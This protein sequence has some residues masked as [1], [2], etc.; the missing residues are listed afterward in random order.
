MFEPLPVVIPTLR[1]VARG[2]LRPA[3][4]AETTEAT[5]PARTAAILLD[6]HTPD[7]PALG[8]LYDELELYLQAV[9]IAS[10][11]LHRRRES[12]VTQMFDIL[13][14]VTLLRSHGCE[15]VILV[16]AAEGTLPSWEQARAE[17]LA[18]LLDLVRRQHSGTARELIGAIADLVKTI[19][20]VA[21]SV[22]GV[23]T[24]LIAPTSPG[25]PRAAVRRQRSAYPRTA[26]PDDAR[27]ATL[28]QAAGSPQALALS[29]SA[30]TDRVRALSQLYLWCRAL[31]D[32]APVKRHAA[33]EHLSDDVLAAE[34]VVRLSARLEARAANTEF[35]AALRWLDEQWS[36]L[37]GDMARTIPHSA[38]HILAAAA[39]AGTKTER[40]RGEALRASRAAWEHLDG[41]TRL[42]WLELCRQ[43]F[44]P[45]HAPASVAALR[46]IN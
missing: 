19:R 2:T 9:G 30:G 44:A 38:A 15:R 40:P 36:E 8:A 32:E 14:S 20:I 13:A 27:D 3:E 16:A 42:K 35:H 46:R 37:V 41:R 39:G 17:T 31:A 1:D 12:T 6:A 25:A 26:T 28:P 21:D 34:E 7:M 11:R 29:L 43:V 45:G 22:A 24:I 23:A 4:P 33:A 5:S 18:S 10:L